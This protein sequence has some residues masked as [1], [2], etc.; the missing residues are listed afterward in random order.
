MILACNQTY[1]EKQSAKIEE[2]AE[3]AENL[4]KREEKEGNDE[5]K[6]HVIDSIK[7]VITLFK[8]LV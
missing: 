2:P 8:D 4:T 5:L 1:R 6:K 3:S 7:A